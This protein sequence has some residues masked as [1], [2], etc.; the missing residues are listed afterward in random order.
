MKRAI[1]WTGLAAGMI[2][3]GVWAKRRFAPDLKFA[4][5]V[6][7]SQVPLLVPGRVAVERVLGA[8]DPSAALPLV[9][10]LHGVAAD[11]AQLAPFILTDQPVR[12]VLLRG[13][14]TSGRGF[15][16]FTARYKDAPA[17]FLEQVAQAAAGVLA[18]IDAIASQRPVS[19][20]IVLGYSQGAH[21]AW[22]LATTGRVDHVIAVSGALPPG[23]PVPRTSSTARIEAA[24][25]T[26]DPVIPFAAGQATARLFEAAGYQVHFSPV[27]L[28]G[29]A[30]SGTGHTVA[31]ALRAALRP[32]S[33]SPARPWG[34]K[35]RG[36]G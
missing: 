17:V 35:F 14:L 6:E 28:A 11:E 15:Q 32:A 3:T 2:G 36:S 25:G 30:L 27:Q 8:A 16:W 10:A 1:M 29:H 26:R 7:P 12:V 5:P 20:R 19:Q 24:H 23:V 22:W 9:V 13:S 21:L 31:P 4:L 33:V 34:L 18:A